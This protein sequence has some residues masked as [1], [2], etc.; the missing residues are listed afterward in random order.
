MWSATR[1]RQA[2]VMRRP[3]LRPADRFAVT[4]PLPAN[5][6]CRAKSTGDGDEV[7]PGGTGSTRE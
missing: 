2:R 7:S 1:S 5:G 3:V 6:G 4:W